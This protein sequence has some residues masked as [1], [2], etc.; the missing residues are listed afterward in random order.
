M[1]RSRHSITNA[2]V[3]LFT[4]SALLALTGCASDGREL[5]DARPWQTTTTRPLPP[6]SAPDQSEGVTGITLSSPDFAPGDFAPIDATCGGSNQPPSLEWAGPADGTAEWA[7]SLSDQTDPSNPLL[8]WLVVGLGP[9]VT[10]LDAATAQSAVETLNDYGQ[11]G[12]GNP[13]V[14]TL[15]NGVRD[16]QFR[17]YSLSAPSG[18]AAG[19]PGNEAWDRVAAG[20]NDSATLLMKVDAAT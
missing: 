11:L 20:A 5:A 14:E 4:S 15:A 12:Y 2:V 1:P 18:I 9:S 19:D 17:L 3:V 7:I 6:T 16:L 8:L 13:C 10:S